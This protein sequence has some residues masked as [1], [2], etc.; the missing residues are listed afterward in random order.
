M[1]P[2]GIRHLVRL[3]YTIALALIAT[4][5]MAPVVTAQTATTADLNAMEA[6]I[7][8][9]LANVTAN[10]QA[11]QTLLNTRTQGMLTQL[12][13][14]ETAVLDVRNATH[15]SGNTQVSAKLATI[16]ALVNAT[17]QETLADH[18]E[19][20]G[21]ATK[22]DEIREDFDVLNE[23]VKDGFEV[24][25][26]G[27]ER[28]FVL[29]DTA[30]ARASILLYVV[31]A[32]ALLQVGQLSYSA[33]RPKFLWR[34]ITHEV[35]KTEAPGKAPEPDCPLTPQRTYGIDGINCPAAAECK[36]ATA[37][38]AKSAERRQQELEAT[39][40]T[41]EEADVDDGDDGVRAPAPIPAAGGDVLA[42]FG[43]P[44]A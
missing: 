8:N 3:Q 43:G 9:R 31:I 5:L 19:I 15:A 20:Y 28:T 30:D 24:S 14:I 23:T 26:E 29:A 39:A 36:H 41:E 16:L 13:V 33:K 1:L 32:L 2:P 11:V 7:N 40:A 21:K 37:C 17:R 35:R 27:N 42:G 34:R 25:N 6:R 10:I 22:L 18:V 4:T 38:K 44:T 12:D